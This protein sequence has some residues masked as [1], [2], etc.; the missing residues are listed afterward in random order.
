VKPRERADDL[1]PPFAEWWAERESRLGGAN[2]PVYWTDAR[3]R[4]V[5]AWGIAAGLKNQI[6]L[7]E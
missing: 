6:A 4:E 1:F 5:N 2:V 3:I 7:E